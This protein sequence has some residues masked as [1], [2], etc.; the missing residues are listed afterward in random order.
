MTNVRRLAA[1]AVLSLGFVAPAIGASFDAAAARKT[2][3]ERY[4]D[5]QKSGTIP[6]G[7]SKSKYVSQCANSLRRDFQLEQE[8]AAQAAGGTGAKSS[9]VVGGASELTATAGKPRAGQPSTSKP[10]NVATP[11]FAPKGQ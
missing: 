10:A 6:A 3:Q 7:M 4:A 8:L 1:I 2:C 9:P 5:E 11:A